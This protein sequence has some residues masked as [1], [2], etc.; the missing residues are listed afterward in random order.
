MLNGT[1]VAT[2][3]AIV[4]ILENHQRPDGGIE[5]PAVLRPLVGADRIGPRA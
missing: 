2:S 5:V 4:A 1:A 3:R